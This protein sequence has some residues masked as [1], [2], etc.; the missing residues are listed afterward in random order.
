MLAEWR[1]REGRGGG[2]EVL[3]NGP[4]MEYKARSGKFAVTLG[5]SVY[6]HCLCIETFKFTNVSGA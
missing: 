5:V 4:L 1:A 3:I 6:K 2:G